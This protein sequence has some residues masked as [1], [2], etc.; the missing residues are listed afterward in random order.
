[1]WWYALMTVFAETVTIIEVAQLRFE[2]LCQSAVE[3]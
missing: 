1:M 2:C 3:E